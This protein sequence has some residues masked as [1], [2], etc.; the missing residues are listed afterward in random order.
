MSANA[1]AA[2]VA[3][4]GAVV[5]FFTGAFSMSWNGAVWMVWAAL[6]AVAGA[7]FTVALFLH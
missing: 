6:F 7:S 4:V 5:C 1:Y 2:I 3:W